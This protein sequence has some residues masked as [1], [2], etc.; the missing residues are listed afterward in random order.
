[1]YEI[2]VTPH[3]MRDL[4]RLPRTILERVD[5]ALLYLK[6]DPYI[7]GIRHLHDHRIADYRIRVGDYRILFD[8]DH[9]KK[10]I[11]VLR[12]RHRKDAY[13]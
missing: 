12:V 3:A 13:R 8:L 4:K 10:L 2:V 1:M 7:P 9:I 5:N 11:I 6:Q